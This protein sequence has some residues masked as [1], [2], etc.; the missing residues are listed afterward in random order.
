MCQDD[1]EGEYDSEDSREVSDNEED[2]EERIK[3]VTTDI[4]LLIRQ[5]KLKMLKF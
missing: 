5:K 2:L 4:D 3:L 1:S